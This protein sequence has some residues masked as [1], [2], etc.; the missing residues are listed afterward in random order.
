MRQRLVIAA[1]DWSALV[2]DIRSSGGVTNAYTVMY[3]SSANV[4]AGNSWL[5]AEFKPDGPVDYSI[6]NRRADCI[7]CQ[8][9]C[10][11]GPQNNFVRTFERER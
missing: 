7:S 6:R 4:L 2:K 8:L 5:W 3:K 11:Q 9:S 10:E 1:V